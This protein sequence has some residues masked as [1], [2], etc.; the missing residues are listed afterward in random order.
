ME[1]AAQRELSESRRQQ[2][3]AGGLAFQHWLKAKQNEDFMRS[4][5]NA[6]LDKV[7]TLKQNNKAEERKRAKEKFEMWRTQKDFESRLQKQN[8]AGMAR[9]LAHP[10]R[11]EYTKDY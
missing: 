3:D 2:R 7:E 8:D 9:L 11:G 5:E 10:P 1:R 4:K 6:Y